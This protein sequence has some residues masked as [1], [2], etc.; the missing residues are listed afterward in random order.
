LG[1][2]PN[3]KM[4]RSRGLL[5]CDLCHWVISSISKD[6]SASIFRCIQSKNNS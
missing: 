5:E 1:E 2:I 6:Q 4:L 3:S